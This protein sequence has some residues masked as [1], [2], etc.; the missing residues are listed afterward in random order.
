MVVLLQGSPIP[1][2]TLDLCQSDH[3]VLGYLPDQ[4]PSPLIAQLVQAACSRKSLGGSNLF[5][6]KNDG[7]HYV[8]GDLQRGLLVPFP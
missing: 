1:T 6:F 8:L 3:Q 2:E 7:G 4:G 5:P